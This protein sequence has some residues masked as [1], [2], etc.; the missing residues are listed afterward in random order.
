MFAYGGAPWHTQKLVS[1]L[2]RQWYHPTAAGLPG[3]DDAGAMS[4]WY[5]FAVLGFYPVC[6]GGG[7][8]G[9]RYI[10][11][12]PQFSSV[13]LALAGGRKLIVTAENVSAANPYIQSSELNGIRFSRSWLTHDEVVAGGELRFTMGS[14]PNF[15]WGSVAGDV[16]TEC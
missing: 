9:P 5:I 8:D 12:T 10:I 6:L 15:S 3:N 7:S 11:G 16:P 14:E 2:T 4:A 1:Q 13:T